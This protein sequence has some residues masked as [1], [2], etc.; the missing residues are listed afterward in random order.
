MGIRGVQTECIPLKSR[1]SKE[2][3]QID[4]LIIRAD[5]VI[6]VCEMKFSID[7]Y[8]ITSVMTASRVTKSMSLPVRPNAGRPYTLYLSQLS[9]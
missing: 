8:I 9:V 4:M 1:Q 7:E 5:N 3:A 6:D 2:G